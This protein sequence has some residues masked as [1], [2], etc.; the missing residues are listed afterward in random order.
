MLTS[1]SFF[2]FSTS[3]A[4]TSFTW[5]PE[6]EFSPGLSP[7]QLNCC[8]SFLC[9][10]GFVL[11]EGLQEEH[12]PSEAAWKTSDFARDAASSASTSSSSL[13]P[14]SCFSWASSVQ[15]SFT[16]ASAR[17]GRGRGRGADWRQSLLLPWINVPPQSY[18]H[19]KLSKT[20][21][22]LKRLI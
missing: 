17:R 18:I 19:D 1:S 16:Q 3:I 12:E 20:N 8:F 11:F 6:C 13:F 15:M 7:S 5:C 22:W 9:R 4:F 14:L 10:L 21:T 2:F